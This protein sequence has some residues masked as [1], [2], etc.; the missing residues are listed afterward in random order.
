MPRLQLA[1]V[2]PAV[3]LQ[4]VLGAA[5]CLATGAAAIQ[6]RVQNA[7]DEQMSAL[8][9]GLEMVAAEEAA[10]VTAKQVERYRPAR[11]PGSAA[12]EA[13]ASAKFRLLR[14]TKI[15]RKSHRCDEKY[16]A[17]PNPSG[18]ASQRAHPQS[19]GAQIRREE[20]K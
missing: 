6:L 4:P 20:P 7:L 9:E 1:P 18:S 13:V 16:R 3:L 15:R 19:N 17:G 11:K 14:R 10:P 5:P 8:A 12:W 2:E